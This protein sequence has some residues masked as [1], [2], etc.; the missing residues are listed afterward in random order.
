MAGFTLIF[1]VLSFPFYYC[2]DRNIKWK[3]AYAS[4][5]GEKSSCWF[6]PH[7]KAWKK[8]K[9]FAHPCGGVSPL[10]TPM[11]LPLMFGR[12]NS[13][14]N[15]AM[16]KMPDIT[17]LCGAVKLMTDK[18]FMLDKRKETSRQSTQMSHHPNLKSV[19]TGFKQGF[20][21]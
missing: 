6:L 16:Q 4:S 11:L 15:A 8:K 2:E 10:H 19:C 5:K 17:K 9:A 7:C 21:I 14:F 20:T 18:R 3:C 13:A 12:W 1:G